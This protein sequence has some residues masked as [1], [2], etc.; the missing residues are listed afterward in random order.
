M[1]F[2]TTSPFGVRLVEI[3]TIAAKLRN[4]LLICKNIA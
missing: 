4:N 1:M 3:S 2:T